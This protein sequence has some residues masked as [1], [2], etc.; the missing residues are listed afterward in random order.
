MACGVIL[1][2]PTGVHPSMKLTIQILTH[3]AAGLFALWLI[4]LLMQLEQGGAGVL[5]L[6][7]A[8][9]AA[10]LLGAV[11]SHLCHEWGHYLGAL[12]GRAPL[13]VKPRPAPLFFDV[14]YERV[15]ARQFLLLSWGGPLGNLLLI[16]L[17]SSR[18]AEG[19]LVPLCAWASSVAMLAYVLVLEGPISRGILAG[20][21]PLPVLTEHFGQ[22]V[23]LLK[24]AGLVALATLAVCLPSGALLLQG[25]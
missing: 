17:L 5:M 19:A 12:L 6:G 10:V 25:A 2:P 21:Q 18:L 22:G 4:E 11:L 23:A 9:L 13:T 24:R 16:G 3:A 1:S 15:T 14:D 20:G 7:L 8:G